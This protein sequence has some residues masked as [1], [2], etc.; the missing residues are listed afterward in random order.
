MID[1]NGEVHP[2]AS[3]QVWGGSDKSHLRL[4]KSVVPQRL[5]ARDTVKKGQKLNTIVCKFNP[6]AVNYLKVVAV[7]QTHS[8]KETIA[9]EKKAEV[10]RKQKEAEAKN[11]GKGK[12]GKKGKGKKKKAAAD[13]AKAATKNKVKVPPPKPKKPQPASLFVNEILVN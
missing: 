4:L 5:T 13:K 10:A 8:L 1:V 12:K 7:R 11:P 9:S 3:M 6:V 2:P